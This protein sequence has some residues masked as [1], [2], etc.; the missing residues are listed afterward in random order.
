MYRSKAMAEDSGI[1]AWTSPTHSGPAVRTR[2]TQFRYIARETA[3]MLF[4]RFTRAPAD[5]AGTGI[6]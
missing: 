2:T 5:D 1:T 6:G 3:A 4:Y